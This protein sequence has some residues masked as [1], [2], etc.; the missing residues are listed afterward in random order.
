[1]ENGQVLE[2]STSDWICCYSHLGKMSA[3]RHRSLETEYQ[4]HPPVTVT[5][6]TIILPTKHK[7]THTHANTLAAGSDLPVAGI[8][9][10]WTW[11]LQGTLWSSGEHH[12][13]AF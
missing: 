12:R 7:Q 6:N 9:L 3:V 8:Q 2:K 11:W 5:T 4:Y 10:G 1:M 13:E